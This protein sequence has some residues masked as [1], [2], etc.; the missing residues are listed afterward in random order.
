[1]IYSEYCTEC[2]WLNSNG[3]CGNKRSVTYNIYMGIDNEYSCASRQYRS[4]EG[5][6][7][8]KRIRKITSIYDYEII[9]TESSR[10]AN[11]TRK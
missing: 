10:Y 1:M 5:G 9:Q 2:I 8:N 3:K 7:L 11:K 4:R 6:V